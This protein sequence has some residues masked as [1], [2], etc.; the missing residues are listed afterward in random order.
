MYRIGFSKDIHR[1]V[2]GRKL[3]IGGTHVEYHLGE[4]AHSDGDVLYHAIA[5][6]ILGALNLG[7]LGRHFP[8]NDS[9]TKNIS[10]DVI[11]N[12]VAQL[13]RQH[14]YEI[15]NVDTQIILEQPKLQNYLPNIQNNI[16]LILRTDKNNVSVK[17]GTNEG[18]DSMGR[19]ES[20]ET[21][22]VVLLKKQLHDERNLNK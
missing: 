6:A 18:M 21:Y 22:A 9:K 5:E 2:E 11:L 15:A 10:S 12:Y 7:D 8:T 17:V 14:H 19:G 4:E 1:L 16:S 20:I 3:I 13:M